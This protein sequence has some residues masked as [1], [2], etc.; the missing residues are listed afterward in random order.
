M[1]AL[2]LHVEEGSIE[3]GQPILAHE[4]IFAHAAQAWEGP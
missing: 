3:S 1:R 2:P 4:A